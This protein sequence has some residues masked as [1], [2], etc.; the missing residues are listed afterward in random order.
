V[1]QITY[2]LAKEEYDVNIENIIVNK[3]NSAKGKFILAK[4]I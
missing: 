1:I 2:F 4:L 3:E